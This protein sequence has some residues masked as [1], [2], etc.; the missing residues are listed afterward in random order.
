MPAFFLM[1]NMEVMNKII[2]VNP[3]ELKKLVE[4]SADQVL[5]KT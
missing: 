2:G 5:S 4:S 1:K 3:D